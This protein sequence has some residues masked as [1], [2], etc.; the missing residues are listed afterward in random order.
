MRK[1]NLIETNKNIDAMIASKSLYSFYGLTENK[2]V[3]IIS[4]NYVTEHYRFSCGGV[5]LTKESMVAKLIEIFEKMQAEYIRVMKIKSPLF[6]VKNASSKMAPYGTIVIDIV[7]E[8][9]TGAFSTIIN[10]AGP[11]VHQFHASDI[12]VRANADAE[13]WKSLYDVVLDVTR[14][15]DKGFTWIK[16]KVAVAW[17][18]KVRDARV[19]IKD[20][21][22]MTG[23][24]TEEQKQSLVLIME[25]K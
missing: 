10:C 22:T 8:T 1:L 9:V 21:I 18:D 11:D 20:C 3:D 6:K 17:L 5:E 15:E 13:V 4:G 14:P 7:V 24:P 23:E 25:R 16:D 19:I 12:W 2:D